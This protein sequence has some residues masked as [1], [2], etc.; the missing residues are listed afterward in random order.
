LRV[1]QN[2]AL[3]EAAEAAGFDVFV[4]TDKNPQYQQNLHGRRIAILVLWTAS[5][6]ELRPQADKISD[7]AGQLAPGEFRELSRPV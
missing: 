2:G 7:A 5:W 6:S 3:L 1:L 4:T